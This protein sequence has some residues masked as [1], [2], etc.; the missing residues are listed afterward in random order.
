MEND[1]IVEQVSNRAP[2]KAPV[3]GSQPCNPVAATVQDGKAASS[4]VALERAQLFPKG[5]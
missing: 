5:I 3:S 1:R 4:I 2:R